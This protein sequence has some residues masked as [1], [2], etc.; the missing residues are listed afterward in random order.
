MI[1]KQWGIHKTT[2]TDVKHPVSV[3]SINSINSSFV[4]SENGVPLVSVAQA[5]RP[6]LD[7]YA[8]SGGVRKIPRFPFGALRG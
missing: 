6:W 4:S 8:P 7:K 1:S 2:V 3:T 5:S